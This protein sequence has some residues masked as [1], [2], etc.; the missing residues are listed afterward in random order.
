LFQVSGPTR[1]LENTSFG[2]AFIRAAIGSEEDGQNGA[3]SS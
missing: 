1:V 2:R 3:I